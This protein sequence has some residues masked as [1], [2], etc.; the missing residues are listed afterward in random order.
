MSWW[1]DEMADPQ[2]RD[3]WLNGMDKLLCRPLLEAILRTATAT[4]SSS[5]SLHLTFITLACQHVVYVSVP[6]G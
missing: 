3:K 4:F 1:G 6:A 5:V 2:T